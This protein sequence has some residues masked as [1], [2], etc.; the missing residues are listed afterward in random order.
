MKNLSMIKAI[1][2]GFGFIAI[3]IASVLHSDLIIKPA[4]ALSNVVIMDPILS[5]QKN[6]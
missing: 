4:Y 2:F 1:L 6:L 5:A 3:A